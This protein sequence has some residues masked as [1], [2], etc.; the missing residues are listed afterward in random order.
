MI[1]SRDAIDRL[2]HQI[3]G[4]EG[5]DHLMVALRAKLLAKQ[6]AMT[7]RMLPIDETAVE[8]RGI[9]PQRLELG[10]LALLPLGLD[11]IDRF[12]REELQRDTVHAAHVWQHI[13]GATDGNSPREFD[14][15]KRPPPAQPNPLETDPAAPA[16]PDWQSDARALPDR[17]QAGYDLGGLDLTVLLGNDINVRRSSPSRRSD[18]HCGRAGFTNVQPVRNS[19]LDVEPPRRQAQQGIGRNRKQD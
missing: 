11:P 15:P 16:G 10:A 6:L 18:G 19:H 13:D 17:K 4:I 2:E 3:A 8:T 12:L 1:K 9:F 14:K 7:C 5:H